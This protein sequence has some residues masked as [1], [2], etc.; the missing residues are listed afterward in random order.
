MGIEVLGY[1][2]TVVTLLSF[3]VEKQLK[4][5]IINTCGAILWVVYG[6][7]ITSN[8]VILTN[9]LIIVFNGKW[10]YFNWRK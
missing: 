8:P 4:L 6:V 5:R 1:V 7:L 2:S 10:L 9:A 3:L